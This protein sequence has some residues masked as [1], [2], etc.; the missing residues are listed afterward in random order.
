[1]LGK[2]QLIQASRSEM[3]KQG[4]PKWVYITKLAWLYFSV[5]DMK[6]QS[7]IINILQVH[8]SDCGDDRVHI[9]ALYRPRSICELAV[10]VE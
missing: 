5:L 10:V 1:M 3:Q 9:A 2:E 7:M 6:I 4:S 8:Q